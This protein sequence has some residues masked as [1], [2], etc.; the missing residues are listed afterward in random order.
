MYQL[1]RSAI[2]GDVNTVIRLSDK[3]AIPMTPENRDYREY[4]EWVAAG[5]V[6]LPPEA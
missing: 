4:L 2:S 3:V 6:P 1:Q 5:N